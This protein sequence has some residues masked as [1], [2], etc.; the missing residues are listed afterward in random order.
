MANAIIDGADAVMLSGETAVGKYPVETVKMMNSVALNTNVY[1]K[2]DHESRGKFMP[3]KGLLT[4]KEAMAR[5]VHLL[6]RDL[7]PKYIIT[8]MH[9]GGSTVF[10]SQQ[11]MHVV[12]HDLLG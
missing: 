3:Y 6:A 2:S 9:S 5:A 1:I 10:L 11:R 7:Q 8:W 4:K 12:I